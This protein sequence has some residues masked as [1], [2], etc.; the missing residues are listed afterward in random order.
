MRGIVVASVLALVLTTENCL[1]VT[2]VQD[3]PTPVM[4]MWGGEGV[5]LD[6]TESGARLQ[7]ACFIATHETPLTANADG[8]FEVSMT[9]A[10][11]G[12]AQPDEV[13]SRPASRVVGSVTGSAMRLTITPED[14][15]PSGAFTLERQAKA[16]LPNCRLRG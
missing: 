7:V 1:M 9:F 4:G 14:A 11:I 16:T 3:T 13:E 8:R 12:G 15:Q 5:R 10:V 6:A 2:A